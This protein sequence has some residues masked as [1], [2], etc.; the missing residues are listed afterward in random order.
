MTNRFCIEAAFIKG[1]WI[2]EAAQYIE[3]SNPA[4]GKVLGKIPALGYCESQAAI[5]AAAEAFP[6]WSDLVPKQRSQLLLNWGQLILAH[7]DELSTLISL[8][9][10]K[11]L[12]EA[13]KELEYGL[14]FIEWFAEEAKRIAGDV[15]SGPQRQQKILT[16]KA[17]IGVVAAIT[18]WNFPLAMITRKC[19]PALA[20]GCTLVVKPSELTPFSALALAKLALEA[21]FPP[22]VLN[23]VTGRPDEIGRAF[24]ED[25]RVRKLSFTGST[26]VGQYLMQQSAG[27]LK[28]LSLELGGNA[29]FIVFEDADLDL[30]V[31]AAMGSKFR[32]TGQTCIC[33]NRFLVAE[34]IAEVFS[35]RLAERV[36]ALKVGPGLEAAVQVGPLINAAGFNKVKALVDDAC[37]LGAKLVTGGYPHALGGNFFQPT[38]L[39]GINPRMRIFQEEIFGPVVSMMTFSAELEAISLANSTPFGLAA[40]VCTKD[41][42]RIL[43]LPELLHFGMIGVNTGVIASECMPFGGVKASGFGREGSRYGIEEFLELR[44]MFVN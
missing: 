41:Y 40:Y 24:L 19:A 22:G 37:A 31:D 15:F 43:R 4:D 13:V 14:S 8:E 3:V 36:A 18:P 34:N 1:A 32:N 29:P 30:A 39:T 23:I 11:P 35:A 28:R 21:G 2:S 20:A 5:D 17:P 33:A 9:C 26:A 12:L 42:Q 38:L 10:G 25:F 44:S 6:A 27:T 16:H 7:K